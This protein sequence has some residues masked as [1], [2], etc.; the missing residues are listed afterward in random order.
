MKVDGGNEIQW[1]RTGAN[2]WL[3][4]KLTNS[5]EKFVKF[6]PRIKHHVAPTDGDAWQVVAYTPRGAEN[7]GA[8]GEKFLKNCGFPPIKG[9]KKGK[10]GTS[11][12]PSKKQRNSIANTA[13]KLSVLFAAL[14][15][16]AS[17]YLCEAVQS[18]VVNDPIVIMEVG[19]FEAT[20]E[21]T[22]LDKAVL[23]PLSWEN[24]LDPDTKE[25]ALHLVRAVTPRHLHLHL[26]SA[27]GEVHG[28]LKLLVQEQLAGGGAVVLQGGQP[29]GVVDDLDHYL[30]YSNNYDG[31]EWTVLARPGNRY[32]EAAG[33]LHPH[34]VLVV[35]GDEKEQED[36]P[37]RIDGSGITFDKGVPGHVQSALKRLHQN[38]G[39]PRVPDLVRHLRLS[40]CE[41][42]VLKAAKGMRCQVCE[43]TR[44]P[45]VARPSS[46]PRMLSFGE[47]VTAD[48]LYAHDCDDKRHV[49]LSLV[50]QPTTWSSSSRIPAARKS[51]RPSTHIG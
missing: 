4:G 11:A 23:E 48:I 25:R 17:S 44:D 39:H 12:R 24:Y 21:A 15:S 50:E 22:E 31:E 43:S 46:L 13:G 33:S 18:E 35:N 20:M 32:L 5:Q 14:I 36:K 29:G 42:S 10:L 2:E 47:V 34:H 9:K 38:L 41:P 37:L 27:P 49:F 8:D 28:D 30:R 7:I 51:S 16:A 26:G 3:P 40:G 19:G 1:K 45:Q 6:D